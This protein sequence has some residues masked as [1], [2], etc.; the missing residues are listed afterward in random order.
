MLTEVEVKVFR[1]IVENEYSDGRLNKPVYSDVIEEYCDVNPKLI[2]NIIAGLTRKGLTNFN[3]DY[4]WMTPKGVNYYK[5][6][7]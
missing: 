3:D 4:T 1:S 6:L 5:E 2:Y 7:I